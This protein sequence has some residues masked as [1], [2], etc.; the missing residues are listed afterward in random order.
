MQ[1]VLLALATTAAVLVVGYGARA[2]I[3]RLRPRVRR[4]M[5]RLRAANRQK[6]QGRRPGRATFSA[7]RRMLH[8]LATSRWP[9]QRSFELGA[10]AG[11]DGDRDTKRS[12]TRSSATLAS[13]TSAATRGQPANPS[14]RADSEG[15]F[16]RP[17]LRAGPVRLAR[18]TTAP[19]RRRPRERGKWSASE[20][21]H[22]IAVRRLRPTPARPL[23]KQKH[24]RLVFGVTT[25]IATLTAAA[26]LAVALGGGLFDRGSP[27]RRAT[28]PPGKSTEPLARAPIVPIRTPGAQDHARA[29]T[30]PP[31]R[32]T[33]HKPRRHVSTAIVSSPAPAPTTPSSV[34]GISS[35]P[36]SPPASRRPAPQSP[37][38]TV[39]S[40]QPRPSGAPSH[41]PGRPATGGSAPVPTTTSPPSHSTS[42]NPAPQ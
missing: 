30:R 4:R 25:L 32:R 12:T 38:P 10:A 42:N 2:M 33:R 21:V 40:S 11:G 19:I 20:T 39:P 35:P 23:D 37:A 36:P 27:A 24:R 28:P 26:A 34:A 22:A 15:D 13:S 3:E 29:G 31:R 41:R 9:A 6:H 7:A 16:G 8:R 17:H 5:Q 1:P 14:R 18:A